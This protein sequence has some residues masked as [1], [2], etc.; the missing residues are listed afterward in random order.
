MGWVDDQTGLL[1]IA[2]VQL[3]PFCAC[4]SGSVAS[5]CVELAP[6]TSAMRNQPGWATVTSTD[7]ETVAPGFITVI[8]LVG[9]PAESP[10]GML[11][12]F[13]QGPF[14]CGPPTVSC[15]I[16]LGGVVILK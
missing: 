8:M 16:Q 4:G 14:F 15:D 5:V 3:V 1:M 12:T 6:S 11:G 2:G 7:T 13:A 9:V 10:R